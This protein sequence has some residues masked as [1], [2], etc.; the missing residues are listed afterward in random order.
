MS[1]E[2]LV[3]IAGLHVAT[4]WRENGISPLENSCAGQTTY[5]GK[6]YVSKLRAS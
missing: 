6:L 1:Y 3:Y 5:P 4:I 2:Q